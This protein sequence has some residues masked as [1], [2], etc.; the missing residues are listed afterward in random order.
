MTNT[1]ISINANQIL[2]SNGVY[3]SVFSGI[4]I[5]DKGK[6][7]IE[8]FKR[9]C[10]KRANDTYSFFPG[11]NPKFSKGAYKLANEKLLEKNK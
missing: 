10:K 2:W 3:E 11:S 6:M 1:N 7:K 9:K 4:D 8:V 5:D